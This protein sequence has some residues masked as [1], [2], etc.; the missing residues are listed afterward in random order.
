VV[1]IAESTIGVEL[2]ISSKSPVSVSTA[3]PPSE[4]ASI[5]CYFIPEAEVRKSSSTATEAA[6]KLPK[7]YLI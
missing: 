3:A 5:N 4:E 7:V 6:P 1:C 2:A